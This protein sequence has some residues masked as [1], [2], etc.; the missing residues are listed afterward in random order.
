MRIT[1]MVALAGSLIA[2]GAEARDTLTSYVLAAMT[3]YTATLACPGAEW[4][5][6]GLGRLGD[7]NGIETGKVLKATL[8]AIELIANDPYE[9]SDLM[10]EVTLRV[11]IVNEKLAEDFKKLGAKAYCAKWLPELRRKGILKP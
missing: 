7:Y 8:A 2:S 10:P 9:R 5:P 1:L 6:N 11:R 3:A 4:Q